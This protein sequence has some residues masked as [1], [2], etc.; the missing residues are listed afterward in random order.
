MGPKVRV[1]LPVVA[2]RT[3]QRSRARIAAQ[4]AERA[5]ADQRYARQ[6]PSLGSFLEAKAGEQDGLAISDVQHEP[7]REEGGVRI[8]HTRA[9]F[10]GTGLRPAVR[11]LAAIENS[12]YPV[13]IERIH[14]DHVQSGDR[15]NFQIGVLAFD[16]PTE[17]GVDA[18]VPAPSGAGAGRAGPPSP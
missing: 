4:R 3:I 7:E 11:L 14:V 10:Q 1:A 16:R 6:A 8:R 12:R 17:G 5:A 2:L 9:R 13:A 18:G 15:Y